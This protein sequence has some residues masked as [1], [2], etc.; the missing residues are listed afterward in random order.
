MVTLLEKLPPINDNEFEKFRDK[1]TLRH[2][3]ITNF[4]TEF[5]FWAAKDKINALTGFQTFPVT[6][7]CFG[8]TH[9]IDNLIMQ[10]GSNLQVLEHDYLYYKRLWPNKEWVTLGTLKSNYPLI[11]ALPFPG[12]GIMHPQ[13]IEL[14]DEAAQK[15][16]DVH[17][18]CAWLPASR[19]INFNFDHPAIKSF[20]ISLS[21]G[22]ALGWNRI[23]VRFSRHV[24][25][26][27][28]ISIANKFNMINEA[29]LSIGYQ[30]MQE[31][32]Y[33]FLW[34]KHSANYQKICKEFKVIPTSVIHTV[35]DPKTGK[36][37]G[38]RDLLLSLST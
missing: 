9:F 4:I 3:T 28:A 1:L 16:V 31:F 5:C 15:N 8:V 27:D 26:T 30:Y 19:N 35:K 38:T 14:L 34:D 2:V 23:A 29:C 24:I 33:N 7:V 10:Y 6:D 37:L 12:Y 11:I 13:M 32:T 17:I 25:D 22:L 36:L 20:A 21:K 18:D